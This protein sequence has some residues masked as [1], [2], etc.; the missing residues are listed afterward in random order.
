MDFNSHMKGTAFLDKACDARLMFLTE[1]GY[2]MSEFSRLKL[3]PVAMRDELE[4][5]KEVG[6][7]QEISVTLALAGMSNDG[8]RWMLRHEILRADGKLC[9]RVTSSGG[10]LDLTDRKLVAPRSGLLGAWKALSQTSDFQELPSSIT[11][12]V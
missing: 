2:P 9:A 10:W 6:L 11:Q 7:L 5:F 12:R 4:Y 3:G 1:H 8:S